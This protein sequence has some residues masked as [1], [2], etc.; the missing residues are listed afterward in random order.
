MTWTFLALALLGTPQSPLAPVGQR[1]QSGDTSRYEGMYGTPE[2]WSL[3]LLTPMVGES[4][5]LARI[6]T[7]KSI[8]TQGKLFVV[9]RPRPDPP[10]G[11]LC[12]EEQRHC[13]SLA[14]PV[15]E[16][17]D[18]FSIEAPSRRGDEMEIVGAFTDQGF[19][20]WSLCRGRP[21]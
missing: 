5:G 1:F 14:K 7:N 21:A 19:V 3:E 12:V 10:Q 6:P 9:M 2:F 4:E 8:R 17:S 11:Q 13:L 18:A 20:F 16:I 15:P